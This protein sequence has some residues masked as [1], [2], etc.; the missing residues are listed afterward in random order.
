M[1]EEQDTTNLKKIYANYMVFI[2]ILGQI[3][4]YA[5]AYKIFSSKSAA[6]LSIVGFTA[7]FISVSSW[8]IYGLIL[9][10]RPLIIANIV[11]C[12]G[13]IAVIVGIIMYR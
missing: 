9:R 10:D 13:A 2:G 4:Y 5:Q 8:L 12:I 6:D 11:A 1:K 3:L 7:G